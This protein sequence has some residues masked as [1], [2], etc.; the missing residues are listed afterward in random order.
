MT[1]NILNFTFGLLLFLISLLIINK[2]FYFIKINSNH[3][4][5][6][7]E[8]YLPAEEIHSLRQMFYLA[9]ITCFFI[10]TFY[11]IVFWHENL[12]AFAVFD[13]IISLICCLNMEFRTIKEK[14]ILFCLIPFSSIYFLVFGWMSID[15]LDITHISIF[16]YMIKVYYVKFEKYTSS[17]GLGLTILLLFIII[18]ISL[19]TTSFS[20]NVNL[21]DS[22]VMIS[23]A[24]TSNGYAVLGE[25]LFGKINSVILVWGG[26]ILS[27]VG[28]ATL[29]AS[30][31]NRNFNK[32]LDH[33]EKLIENKK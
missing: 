1:I 25:S 29:T 14:L 9:M 19:F 17:N 33:L 2:L 23:N 16:I 21:L 31:M 22:L 7:L 8:E 26:Y 13:I 5:L 15:F 18:F 28:T 30:I 4:F 32:K 12:F 24:F 10:N 6:N 3:K 11:F 20:E 27:G